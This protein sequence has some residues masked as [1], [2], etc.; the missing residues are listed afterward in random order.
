MG[1]GALNHRLVAGWL[2]EVFPSVYRVA[3]TDDSRLGRV[4]AAALSFQGGGLIC[5]A[6]A[7][8]LWQLLDTTQQPADHAPV[9]VLLV[10]RNAKSRPGVTIHRIKVL[11]R[12]DTRW[13]N[14]IPVTSPARTILDLA[15]TMDEME[16]EAV[17]SSGLR[18]NV[19]RVSQLREVM[20]RNP[21]AKGIG[22]LRRLLE[23]PESLHDT[24]SKYERKLLRLLKAAE[25]PLPLTNTRV[26]GKSVDGVWPDLKL[27][28]EFD[29]WKYHRDRDKF[30]SDRIRDQ[31]LLIADHRVMR[32]TKRQIDH[33][34]YALIAR[35]ATMIATLRLNRGESLPRTLGDA[36]QEAA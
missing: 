26:A 4:M 30:E 29:G 22:T 14:G 13:R 25:L 5:G 24:R 20:A 2:R 31:H 19:V 7:G 17:I 11:A 28:L 12:Q 36:Q 21:R 15:A 9:D 23:Q 16:L 6:A 8:S 35:V 1:R 3:G 18:K 32:V 34:P 33:R 27:V 10:A